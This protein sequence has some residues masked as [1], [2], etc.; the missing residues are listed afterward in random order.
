MKCSRAIRQL[1]AYLD[2][3]LDVSKEKRLEH[4]LKACALCCLE[5]AALKK[6]GEA[7]DS[8]GDTEPHKD[9]V[10]PV[11][12]IL[13][14]EQEAPSK[15][16]Q[17]IELIVENRRKI[18][19]VGAN[20]VIL[21]LLALRVPMFLERST[22]TKSAGMDTTTP[23][24]LEPYYAGAWS[25]MRPVYDPVDM[26]ADVNSMVDRH[27]LTPVEKD[28]IVHN[29]LNDA[30]GF[31]EASSRPAVRRRTTRIRGFRIIHTYNSRN[32]G[33]QRRVIFIQRMHY[34]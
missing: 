31:I 32:G 11:M 16:Q 21:V 6:T 29:F 3:E 28:M 7:M 8:L 30:N 1:Q 24:R 13:R 20:M 25:A 2:N 18:L 33:T 9:L 27:N 10:S 4:H 5:F 22:E 12:N 34:E 19:A 14:H 17:F 23:G 15:L 26:A